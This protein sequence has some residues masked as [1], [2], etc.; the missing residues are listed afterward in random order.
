MAGRT[1][2]PKTFDPNSKK[3]FAIS[4][5]KIDIFS[6]CP[7]CAY[8][9]MR[10]GVKRVQGPTFTLNN[11]VDNLLK[12]EFDI[13]RAK[14]EPHP[15]MAH[16]KIDAVPFEH[17]DMD[18]WR[19]NF[20]GVRTV[21]EESGFE[22]FGAVDDIWINTK[23]TLHV[24]DYKATAKNEGPSSVE[25]LYP[26]YK[27]QMDVYQWLLRQN[28]FDVSDIG[29]FVYVNGRKDE[30][31]FDGKLEFD[32]ALIS[33]EGND[34]WVTPALVK[35]R[36]VLSKDTVPEVGVAFDGVSPCEYCTY[37]E[38]AG[39]KIRGLYTEKEKLSQKEGKPTLF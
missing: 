30:R 39:K 34:A 24:V 13:H 2:R 8:L 37:R 35:L 21:H 5:S 6:E 29:Y 31:A 27:R 15:M 10:L 20:T 18:K 1:Y 11:A 7:R 36:E 14:G 32:T 4:R 28:G 16:Y 26:S 3:P 17:Q 19:H 33:Y 12:K 38:N 25:D 23:G 22:V 9:D